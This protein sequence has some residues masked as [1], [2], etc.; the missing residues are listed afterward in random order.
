MVHALPG[1]SQREGK[2]LL[3][4]LAVRS[5]EKVVIVTVVGALCGAPN[6]CE[7]LY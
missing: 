7:I 2:A 3:I 6:T 5:L 1:T 4:M